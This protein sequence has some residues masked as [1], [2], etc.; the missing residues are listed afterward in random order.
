MSWPYLQYLLP[1]NPFIR[2][3]ETEGESFSS[4]IRKSLIKKSYSCHSLLNLVNLWTGLSPEHKIWFLG[5]SDGCHW[6]RFPL[7]IYIYI[8]P[9]YK[10]RKSLPLALTYLPPPHSHSVW[11]EKKKKIQV[12]LSQ[13]SFVARGKKLITVFKENR[14][15][16]LIKNLVFHT[17]LGGKVKFN[18]SIC[19]MCLKVHGENCTVGRSVNEHVE[20]AR[21]A[22]TLEAAYAWTAF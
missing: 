12:Q 19:S 2:C 13:M 21:K 4:H 10:C 8:I 14:H 6:N 20:T 7:G 9:K 16:P 18:I 5:T 15:F 22:P 11:G 1:K 17:S 3:G